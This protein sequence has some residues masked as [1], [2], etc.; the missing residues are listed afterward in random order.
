[1]IIAPD[2]GTIIL[3]ENGW[4]WQSDGD[5]WYPVKPQDMA[6]TWEALAPIV[7]RVVWRP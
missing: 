1:M 5:L 7:S 6:R 2:A 3:D 4:A